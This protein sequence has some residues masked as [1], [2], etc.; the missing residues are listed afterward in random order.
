MS[1]RLRVDFQPRC[2]LAW[3]HGRAVFQFLTENSE[4]IRT[5]AFFYNLST[6]PFS[7]NFL[8][9]AIQKSIQLIKQCKISHTKLEAKRVV[10]HFSRLMQCVLDSALLI[11]NTKYNWLI[12]VAA[13]SQ[14]WFC[15][16][17]FT[18][19]AGSNPARGTDFS[20]ECCLL[21][22]RGLCDGPIPLPEES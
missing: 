21:T 15:G 16:R 1:G 18:G 5:T 3:L 2:R 10:F 6:S 13:R 19:I 4:V 14:A 8:Y 9:D 7:L 20:C 11:T 12:P 22:G 17:L